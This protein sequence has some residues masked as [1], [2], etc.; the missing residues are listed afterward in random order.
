MGAV[1]ELRAPVRAPVRAGRKARGLFAGVALAAL[2]CCS[3]EAPPAASPSLDELLARGEYEAVIETADER[4]SAARQRGASAGEC[5]SIERTRLIALSRT[6][7][8]DRLLAAW[9]SA[10]AEYPSSIPA[11]FERELTL[12]L[13]RADPTHV[14]AQRFLL[15]C[16]GLSSNDARRAGMPS[17]L[18]PGPGELGPYGHPEGFPG[19]WLAPDERPGE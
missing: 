1:S 8:G 15:A 5:W 11:P 18:L 4:L 14:E 6:A 2:L 16:R 10:Q 3:P 13:M 12:E 19:A 9:Q 7:Q 17:M